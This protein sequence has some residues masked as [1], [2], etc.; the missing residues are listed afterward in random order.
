[1][2]TKDSIEETYSIFHQKWRIFSTSATDEQKEHIKYTII[3]YV[4]TMN[5]DL[6]A[7]LSN[8]KEDFL[9]DYDTF[10]EDMPQA[11][12]KLEELLQT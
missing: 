5:P 6:Y 11:M 7:L 9:A 4:E 12:Q 8:G 3:S 10:E 2:I 1:M